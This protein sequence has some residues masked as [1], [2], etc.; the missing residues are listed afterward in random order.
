MVVK[1]YEEEQE[2][3]KKDFFL[4]NLWQH[5]DIEVGR[6]TKSATADAI[7][8]VQRYLAEDNTARS[9]DPTRY[10]DNQTTIYPNLYRLSSQFLCTPAS[11]V[12]CER[13]F[14]TAG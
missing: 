4:D 7:Q 10:Q 14:S 6:Q 1:K 2:Q 11:S 9:Q 12:P 13:V 3:M 8:E 5:L